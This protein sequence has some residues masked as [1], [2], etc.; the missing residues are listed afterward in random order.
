MGNRRCARSRR[1]GYPPRMA[2]SFDDTWRRC[3]LGAV[4]GLLLGLV[5]GIH[6]AVAKGPLLP[7][8]LPAI[9]IA[10]QSATLSF[11]QSVAERKSWSRPKG[12]VLAVLLSIAFG[13]FTISLHEWFWSADS[14]LGRLVFGA[15]SAGLSVLMFWLLL[16]YFP[17]QLQAARLR[18]LAAESAQRKAELA[19][20]R[21]NLHPHFLLNTLNAV[22]GLLVSEPKQARQLVIALGELLRDSL[23]ENGELRPLGEEVDWL[24]HY[25][26]IFEI[27]HG[28]AIRFDWDLANDTLAL[29][30]PRLLLQPLLENAIE[31][32]VLQR[33]GGG[34]IVLKSRTVNQG[35][36]ISVSDDG[37]GWDTDKPLGLGLRLVEERLL[38]AYP[39]AKMTIDARQDRTS[40]LLDIPFPG[41]PE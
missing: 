25:A 27:R 9:P 7:A 8:F 26:E 33:P 1:L 5:H 35:V 24:R 12:A 21:S 19:R 18:A 10:L 14:L 3:T 13:I 40:V 20:L 23:E 17:G 29:P 36:R 2:R 32:G 22:A 38:L 39:S 31:H 34:T 6:D 37:P 15:P 41:T 16:L 28:G 4:V 30:I 11:G